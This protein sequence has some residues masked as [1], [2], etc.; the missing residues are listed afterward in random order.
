MKVTYL[1]HSGFLLELEDCYIIFDYYRG[2]LPPLNKKKEV[3]VFAVTSM[4]IIIIRRFFPCS[5]GRG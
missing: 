4:G 2:E 5:T 3:F 1:N